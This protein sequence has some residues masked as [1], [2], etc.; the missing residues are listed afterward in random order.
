MNDTIIKVSVAHFYKVFAK[1][2]KQLNAQSTTKPNWK[3]NSNYI[4]LPF[5]S[6]KFWLK[7][8]ECKVMNLGNQI[9]I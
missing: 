5:F 4:F 2:I 1:G 3:T 7:K 8:I 6:N 9:G